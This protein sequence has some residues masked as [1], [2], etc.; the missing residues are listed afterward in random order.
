MN[1]AQ[2][3]HYDAI[4]QLAR[5]EWPAEPVTIHPTPTASMTREQ[6]REMVASLDDNP[7]ALHAAITATAAAQEAGR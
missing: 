7:E 1:A 3:R 4:Q 5:E 6:F 2:R